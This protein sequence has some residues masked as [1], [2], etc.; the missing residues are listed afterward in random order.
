MSG[1]VLLTNTRTEEGQNG[2]MK[3]FENV[4]VGNFSE[5]NKPKVPK[6]SI[7]IR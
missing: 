4:L 5:E 2:T 3:L 6:S 1:T 7:R